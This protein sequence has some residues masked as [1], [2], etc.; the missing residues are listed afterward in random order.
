[1]QYFPHIVESLTPS[2]PDTLDF[3]MVNHVLMSQSSALTW[4]SVCSLTEV[5]SV[6]SVAAAVA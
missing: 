5:L 3:T 1:M 2:T 6:D 4:A